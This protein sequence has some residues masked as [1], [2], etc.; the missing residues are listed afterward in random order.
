ME[1]IPYGGC[2]PSGKQSSLGNLFYYLTPTGM[3]YLNII[4]IFQH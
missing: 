3:S 2:F 1:W 4:S